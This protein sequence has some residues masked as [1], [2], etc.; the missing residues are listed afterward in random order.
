MQRKLAYKVLPVSLFTQ[1]PWQVSEFGPIFLLQPF[2]K[3]SQ[4][5]KIKTTHM[6]HNSHIALKHEDVPSSGNHVFANG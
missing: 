5:V 4:S 2:R 6:V 3:Y 1:I